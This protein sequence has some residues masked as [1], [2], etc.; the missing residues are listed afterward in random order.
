MAL[1]RVMFINL[2]VKYISMIMSIKITIP[3]ELLLLLFAD[4]LSC[5]LVD[6]G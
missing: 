5:C 1:S 4:R 3:I 2:I 6:G